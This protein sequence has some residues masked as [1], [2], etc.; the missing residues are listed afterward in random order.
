ML[1]A[2]VKNAGAKALIVATALSSI[3]SGQ[4]RSAIPAF[5]TQADAITADVVVLD[6]DGRPV[7][8]LTRGDFTLLED[9]KPQRS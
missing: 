4:E 9:G 8:D 5:P 6:K 1:P 7:R 3:A 2:T